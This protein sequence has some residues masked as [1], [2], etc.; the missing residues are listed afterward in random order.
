MFTLT[1]LIPVRDNDGDAFADEILAPFEQLCN[2][3][4]GGFTH[5]HGMAAGEWVSAAGVTYADDHH[6][7]IVAISSIVHG[8]RV[9]QLVAFAKVQFRQETICI[10]YLGQSEILP[11]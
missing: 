5:F 9:A 1:V 10:F 3:L 11:L 4:F 8:G 7:Y 2:E 6:V